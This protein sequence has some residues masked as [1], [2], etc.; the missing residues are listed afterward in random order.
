VQKSVFTI[1]LKL[2]LAFGTWTTLMIVVGLGAI[3]A[4]CRLDVNAPSSYRFSLTGLI[5]V[6]S[7]DVLSQSIVA[8]I[9]TG[10]YAAG[11]TAWA[12]NLRKSRQPSICQSDPRVRG[13]TNLVAQP[14]HL[15]S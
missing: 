3:D 2:M 6:A 14:S 1:R 5:A 10:L 13:W 7:L 4:L 11:F 9:F 12:E 8:P 15:I